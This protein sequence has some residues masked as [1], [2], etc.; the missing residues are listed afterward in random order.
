MAY[1]YAI[2]SPEYMA[3]IT[4]LNKYYKY[5]KDY[6]PNAYYEKNYQKCKDNLL[7]LCR[8][9]NMTKKEETTVMKTFDKRWDTLDL[10]HSRPCIA[11]IKRS[12]L[13]K[14]SLKNITEIINSAQDY[15]LNILMSKITD[16]KYPVI[17]K[18][19]DINPLDLKVVTMPS[20]REIKNN[21]FLE[22]KK[23]ISSIEESKKE[24]IP[25]FKYKYSY[26]LGNA[27]IIALTGLLLISLGLTL[28]IILKVVGG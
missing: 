15:D 18:Y 10:S 8:H 11:F 28:S 14:D 27:N 6:Y 2:R 3:E 22:N 13:A 26:S 7:S 16:S 24:V 9:V 20:Y 23:E 1:F 25:S 12:D 5:V 21:N 4:S 17:R 19:S